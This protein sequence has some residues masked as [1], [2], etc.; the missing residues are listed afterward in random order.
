MHREELTGKHRFNLNAHRKVLL[1]AG[2]RVLEWALPWA[3]TVNRCKG[4]GCTKP[5][6]YPLHPVILVLVS[7]G[8]ALGRGPVAEVEDMTHTWRLG[9]TR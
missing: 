8:L 7:R 6:G 2:V 9:G 4:L 5:G 3:T 1:K